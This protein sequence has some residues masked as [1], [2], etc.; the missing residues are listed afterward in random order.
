MEGVSGERSTLDANSV[1]TEK[2]GV[3]IVALLLLVALLSVFVLWTVNPVG[4]GSESTF[5]LYVAVD[6]VS[7]A[8]ISYVQR[9]IISDGR[10]GRAPLIAGCCFILF[11]VLAGFYLLQ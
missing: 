6:L 5:A 2:M 4:P 8:M 10:I 1:V 7:V 11:L 9:S 3:R